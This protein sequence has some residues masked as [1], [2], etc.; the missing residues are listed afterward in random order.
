[1]SYILVEPARQTRWPHHTP[2]CECTVCTP[3]HGTQAGTHANL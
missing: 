1:M 2:D 3:P